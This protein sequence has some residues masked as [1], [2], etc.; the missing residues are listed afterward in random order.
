[1][2]TAPTAAYTL[3]TDATNPD[4]TS[5]GIHGAAITSGAIL[6]NGGATLGIYGGGSPET[7][8]TGG[9]V[10]LSSNRNI[11]LASGAYG[12]S[13][14]AAA[15][16][17]VFTGTTVSF[18]GQ[19]G[20]YVGETGELN[21]NGN[22]TLNLSGSNSYTGGTT[23]SAGRL[24]ANAASGSSTGTGSVNVASGAVLGGTGIIKPGAST[25]GVI[26]HNGATL[27]SGAYSGSTVTNQMTLDNTVAG[28]TILNAVSGSNMIFSLGTG[29]TG[30][31]FVPSL[32]SPTFS[33][34]NTNS[35]YLNILG[36]TA[37]ELTFAG[38]GVVMTVNDLTAG[39]GLQFYNNEAYLLIAATSN[40][41]YAGL[42]TDT[43]TTMAW[44]TTVM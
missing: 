25:N 41:D 31:A 2:G 43:G 8:Y 44:P 14:T 39:A 20:D 13:P 11:L 37:G 22:G 18:G 9:N 42:I 12:S 15:N 23:V 21:K 35:T 29:N 26:L 19:I 4:G 7:G 5:T 38:T 10:T 17:D 40:A 33:L 1:M 34:V 16:I 30:I 27:A 3:N 36:N 32:G 28:S 24:N 6:I